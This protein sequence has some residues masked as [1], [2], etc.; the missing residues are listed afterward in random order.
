MFIRLSVALGAL[1][2]LGDEVRAQS[3]SS[4]GYAIQVSAA[5]GAELDSAF[6]HE[7]ARSVAQR[8]ATPSLRRA[9]FV[10]WRR[11]RDRTIPEIPRWADD[12]RPDSTHRA[13]AVLVIRRRGRP[14]ISAP[15]PA[16]G[17]RL[18]DNS[19][20]SIL[21]DPLPGSPDLPAIPA[22]V[23][24]DSLALR[25]DFGARPDAP[26]P[27]VIRFASVQENVILT[28]GSLNVQYTQRAPTTLRN[29]NAIGGAGQRLDATVKYDVTAEGMVDPRSIQLIEGGDRD[30][31]RAVQDALAR[32]RFTPATTNCR[33][34]RISVI[35]RFG[36]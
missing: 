34:V 13:T 11:V 31:A 16:S 33:P 15:A 25:I 30:F 23:T 22:N 10:N 9:D 19:L 12:W 20:E 17:D 21:R 8:W 29:P 4:P 36:N 24:A 32:A 7:A 2:V 3:C 5:D 27:G 6:L 1:T 14:S 35:Q 18:F 26:L 28:P